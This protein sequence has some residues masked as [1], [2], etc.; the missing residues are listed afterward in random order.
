MYLSKGA[1]L[2]VFKR[3]NRKRLSFYVLWYIYEEERA[4]RE[5][6]PFHMET[7]QYL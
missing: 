7:I 3:K 4:K 1:L 5:K 2:Y 6:K